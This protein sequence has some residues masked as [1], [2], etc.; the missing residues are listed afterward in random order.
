LVID[1]TLTTW[2]FL[3]WIVLCLRTGLVLRLSL[4]KSKKSVI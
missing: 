1:R 2:I 3:W 4:R